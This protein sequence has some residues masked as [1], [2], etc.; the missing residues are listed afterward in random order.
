[1][2]SK[3]EGGRKC[4]RP[5]LLSL[6]ECPVVLMNFYRHLTELATYAGSQ[7]LTTSIAEENTQA[8]TFSKSGMALDLR[9]PLERGEHAS[10]PGFIG[11][12]CLKEHSIHIRYRG[13][14]QGA[15]HSQSFASPLSI[16][17]D[18]PSSQ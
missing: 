9:G 6:F 14:L 5:L 18:P 16:D 8:Q 7:N 17:G 11:G 13:N 2:T 15:A 4:K 12:G 3:P 10:N 1:M